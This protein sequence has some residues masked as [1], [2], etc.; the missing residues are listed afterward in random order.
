MPDTHVVHKFALGNSIH[1]RLPEGRVLHIAE[2]HG[3]I[4][5]WLLRPLGADGKP[6]PAETQ[7]LTVIGTGFRFDPQ[8]YG[9]FVGTAVVDGGNYVFHAYL[10]PLDATDDRA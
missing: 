3:N 4:T 6:D 8:A 10:R 5:L 2:Q 7:E 9:E 1:L